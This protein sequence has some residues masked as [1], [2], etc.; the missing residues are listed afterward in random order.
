M[1]AGIVGCGFISD[2]YLQN[3]TTHFKTPEVVACADLD[4]GRARQQ[5]DKYAI[6]ALSMDELLRNPDIELIINL[7]TPA[8]HKEIILAA[9]SHGKHVYSE[10]PLATS[11][12]DAQEILALARK[13]NLQVGC[14]P[15]TLLGAGLQTALQ[16]VDDGRVGK[17]LSATAFWSSRGHERWHPNAAFYYQYGGGPLLDMG[18]YYV[19][20]L[21]AALGQVEEVSAMGSRAF[22]QRTLET[23]PHAGTSFDVEI[24]THFSASL[25]MAS[26][27]IVTLILSFDIWANHLPRLEIYG[28][29]GT[30]SV[31]DP[32]TFGG[33]VQLYTPETGEFQSLPP[34][35]QN[36]GNMRG[37]GAMQMSRA[38]ASGRPFLTQA[39]LSS[40]VLEILLGIERSAIIGQPVKMKTA[41][42][43][44]AFEAFTALE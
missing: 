37:I 16:A 19:S 27:V 22:K 23:G 40:H 4:A 17:L 33:D 29:G 18:P 11:M 41:Y 21:V 15:D 28:T 6:Q 38:I 20:M 32:N 24:D 36:A 10:K 42:Q 2:I 8:A 31:P 7:T 26:G 25:R 34:V 44:Q 13:L 12:K 43:K 9:L 5:A 14:S 30:L 39:N 35:S 3:L 1:K